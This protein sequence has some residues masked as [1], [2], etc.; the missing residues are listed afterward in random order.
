MADDV[1]IKFRVDDKGVLDHLKQ[2]NALQKNLNATQAKTTQTNQK[3][4]KVVTTLIEKIKEHG[5]T[6]KQ[7]GISLK[8]IKQALKGN[9]QAIETIRKAESRYYSEMAARRAQIKKNKTAQDKATASIN[10]NTIAQEKLNQTM[11]KT[12]SGLFDIHTKNRLVEG[13]FATMRSKLLLASFAFGLVSAAI[14]RNIEAF[15]K[16]EESVARLAMVF[17]RLAS[18]ELQQYASAL[19]KVTRFGDESI[20][21]VMAQFGA[22]GATTEQTK[23]LTEATL[24]L[25]EGT[26]MDLNS[27]A[28]IIAK[29]FGTSTNALSRYGIELDSNMT[30]QEKINAI[31][32][33]SEQRYGGLSELLGQLSGSS[34][35][36]LSMAMG[37]LQERM[38]EVLA[39][40]LLPVIRGLTWLV[41]SLNTDTI[42]AMIRH[43]V[44]LTIAFGLLKGGAALG[45]VIR[46]FKAAKIVAIMYNT[47][48]LMTTGATVG[49]T[50]ASRVFF[51]TLVAGTGGLYGLVIVVGM[52]VTA[53]LSLFGVFKKNNNEQKEMNKLLDEANDKFKQVNTGNAVQQLSDFIAKLKETNDVLKIVTSAMS[54]NFFDTFDQ[55]AKGGG[56]SAI[57]DLEELNSQLNRLN[58]LGL[59]D[60]KEFRK[61]ANKLKKEEL[62]ARDAL[63]KALGTSEEDARL[64]EHKIAEAR[65]NGFKQFHHNLKA[66]IAL[67]TN[68]IKTLNQ[69]I[70]SNM[71]SVDDFKD[72]FKGATGVT[73]DFFNTFIAG[74]ELQSRIADGSIDTNQELFAV[75]ED[76]V[77]QKGEFSKASKTEQNDM[78][79]QILLEL[80]LTDGKKQLIE[81]SVNHLRVKNET[82]ALGLG[83]L[84]VQRRKILADI[85]EAEKIKNKD[86]VILDGIAARKD[87]LADLDAQIANNKRNEELSFIIL[88]DIAQEKGKIW[89]QLANNFAS[90]NQASKG[91]ALVTARLQQIAATINAVVSASSAMRDAPIGMKAAAG[92]AAYAM[93]M[94]R[95]IQIEQQLS[96]MQSTSTSGGGAYGSF[97]YGG[98]VGGNRHSQGGTLIEA[99]RGEF[100][101][102]RRAVNAIGLETL[103]NMNQSGGGSGSVT[104]NVS[105][106]VLT[107]DYVEG[108]LAESIKEAVRR[109]SDFGLS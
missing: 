39:D 24:D 64:A 46:A 89:A 86:Q 18:Q 27:A 50:T 13:S 14:T 30:Q 21:A 51:S 96:K 8:T 79:D 106:N 60:T 52:A 104:V 85:E 35:K 9:I 75:V 91:S 25:A 5:R 32:K 73:D 107:Q 33:Q 98:Y 40:G 47:Q 12:G 38:G 43:V 1:I 36:Q 78:I 57:K 42:R 103:N 88:T 105:G 74:S 48:L 31:V 11:K 7:L 23:K 62:K 41:E 6:T 61:E 37:D 84:E 56:K 70:N 80:E 83:D 53:I 87:A 102:S 68:Q 95:V 66:E 16:Q 45:G 100:V 109:G 67:I 101:M 2:L 17:G 99:E 77:K 81:A 82:I 97:E 71:M 90:L 19:Q 34:T 28:L 92:A 59:K 15:A 58:A 22:Y 93:G 4:R 44:G 20:N 49:A 94:A 108:E 55:F 72:F 65:F 76:I 10:K 63:N 54:N 26:Q 69:N 29:S 3:N